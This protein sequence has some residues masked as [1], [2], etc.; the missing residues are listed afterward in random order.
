MIKVNV[1]GADDISENEKQAYINRMKET[2]SDP[3]P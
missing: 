1:H 2:Y 3:V